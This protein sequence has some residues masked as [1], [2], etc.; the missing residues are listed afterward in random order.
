MYDEK[1]QG[2]REEQLEIR[3]WC[4]NTVAPNNF[5]HAFSAIS[6]AHLET[7]YRKKGATLIVRTEGK[8]QRAGIPGAACR[9]V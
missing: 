1:Y 7:K 9:G 2:K 3:A 6:G 5:Y 4:L 8:T